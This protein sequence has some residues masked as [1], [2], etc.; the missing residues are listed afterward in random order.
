MSKVKKIITIYEDGTETVSHPEIPYQAADPDMKHFGITVGEIILFP[1]GSFKDTGFGSACH[2]PAPLGGQY[3]RQRPLRILRYWEAKLE[4]MTKEFD[5]LKKTLEQNFNLH[6]DKKD[7]LVRLKKLQ[8][9]VQI[10]ATETS[11]AERILREASPNEPLPSAVT[12]GEAEE[13]K[14]FIESIR[15]IEI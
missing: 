1:D 5:K 10:A 8:T 12:L 6:M 14:D 15:E 7:A 4:Q 2:Q 3:P 13:E 9:K 11:K